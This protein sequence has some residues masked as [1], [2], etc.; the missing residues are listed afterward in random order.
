M[1]HGDGQ[2]VG[3]SLAAEPRIY[4][5][6]YHY[7]YGFIR[8]SGDR[9]EFAGDRARFALD[10]RQVQS[11]RV[12]DGPRHWTPRPVVCLEC[13]PST[14][15]PVATVALQSFEARYWPGTR[16]AAQR[17]FALLKGWQ[18]AATSA[19]QPVVAC[20]IPRVAGLRGP[21][22]S[23]RMAF[24]V[25]LSYGGIGFVAGSFGNL[26]QVPEIG[27]FSAIFYPALLSA[28]VALF[29]AWPRIHWSMRKEPPSA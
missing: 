10:R 25:A 17:L 22:V 14:G 2:F 6:M 8:L 5:G 9:I 15:E 12:G 28:A 29:A 16:F 19:D 18:S 24:R 23:P 13:H 21:G 3:L 4:D 11:V 20:E 1:G 27:S 26:F 7:D